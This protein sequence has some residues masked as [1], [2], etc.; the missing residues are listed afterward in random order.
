MGN[1]LH[2]K[3]VCLLLAY[4]LNKYDKALMPCKTSKARRLLKDNKAKV[5]NRTPFT[6]QLLH[7]SSGYKQLI[8]LG[9]DSGS[10]IIGLSAT[11]E[12][13]E[14]FSAEVTLRK[15]IVY[16]LSTRRKLR[17]NRRSLKTRYRKPRLLNRVKSKNKGLMAPSIENKIQTH[18]NII[19]KIHKILP[20]SKIIVEIANFDI[21]KIKNADIQ[22]I[23]C[24]QGEE[25]N[26]WNV[27]EYV[28]FRDGHKCHGKKG[29]NNK[30][31]NVH[32]IESR[33]IGGDTPNNLITL[34]EECHHN[35]H[36]GKLKF[37][38]KRGDSFRDAA[39]MGVMRWAFYNRLK[40]L[41]SNVKMAYGYIT[42]N[43]RITNNLPKERRVDAR[44]ISKNS[45]ARPLDNWFY[46]KQVRKHNRMIHKTRIL[47][48]GLRKLNQAPYIVK[49]FRLYDKV[50]YNNQECFISGMRSRGYFDLRLLD[51]TKIYASASYKEL[52]L[53]EIGKTLLWK[54]SCGNSSL[55]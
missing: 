52:R 25:M 38:F 30:I 41:Y 17:R 33:K 3:E 6:I 2:L 12:S 28:L 53:L 9:V 7:G 51:D 15:D 42:K 14:L 5:V 32:H 18:F 10:K 29:C 55:T 1:L 27:R 50:K 35:Y 22:R 40:E 36:K 24:N 39:F 16:L 23:D 34:C 19:E 49:G 37:N 21:E 46:I 20:V 11:T 8:T 13:K 45:L 26:F 44:C 48:G 47:K 54:V 31:L 4:V 43:T